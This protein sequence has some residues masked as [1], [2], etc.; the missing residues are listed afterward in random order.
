MKVLV[1]YFAFLREEKGCNEEW[2]E[3][4]ES[5]SIGELFVRLFERPTSGIRFAINQAYV[6]ADAVLVDG[7][8]VAFIPPLGG[9]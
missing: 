2:I 5:V 4:L 6:N 3:L 1:R 8:E 7:D 9:G